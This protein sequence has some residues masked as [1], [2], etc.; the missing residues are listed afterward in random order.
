MEQQLQ[1]D[2]SFSFDLK[3][4]PLFRASLYQ[5]DASEQVLVLEMHHI[6][7][8]GWSLGVIWRDLSALD[9]YANDDRNPYLYQPT[10]PDLSRL[11]TIIAA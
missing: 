4:G 7:S 9:R 5:L 10:S 6:V 1:D 11:V 3:K 2:R 8:D